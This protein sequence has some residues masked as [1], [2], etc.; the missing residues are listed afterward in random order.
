MELSISI[1]T[2][3]S[4]NMMGSGELLVGKLDWLCDVMY[5]KKMTL[6]VQYQYK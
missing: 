4:S 1:L 3:E 5:K 6:L 2:T